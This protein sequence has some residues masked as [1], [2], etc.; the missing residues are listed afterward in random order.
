MGSV[1]KSRDCQDLSVDILVKNKQAG[2]QIVNK[3][4]IYFS[5]LFTA[6]VLSKVLLSY[7]G[8]AARLKC[9]PN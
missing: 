3:Y 7:D 2:K 6:D 4:I 5:I 9:H 1:D 8:N